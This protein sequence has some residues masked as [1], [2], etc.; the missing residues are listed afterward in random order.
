MDRFPKILVAPLALNL[1]DY[2]RT[3]EELTIVRFPEHFFQSEKAYNRLLKTWGFFE[4]FLRYEYILVHQLDCYVFE[5]QLDFWCGQGYD[6]VGAPWA[7]FDWLFR[8]RRGFIGKL[9]GL[10]LLMNKVGNGGFSLRKV[11]TFY[12]AAK[13]FGLLARFCDFHEDLFWSNVVYR[14]YPNFSI[15]DFQTALGFAFELEP[16]RC[17]ESNSHRLPFG[18]HAWAQYDLDFWETKFAPEDVLTLQ[19]HGTANLTK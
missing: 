7:N 4:R 5:D 3:N 14:L 11:S 19:Q 18:C 8:K 15:P 16:R 6:Y 9:P 2:L 1:D 13:R 12:R 17:Y 10:H